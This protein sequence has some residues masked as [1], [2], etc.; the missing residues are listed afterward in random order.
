MSRM[1][2]VRDILLEYLCKGGFDG[3]CSCTD[4]DD[5]YCHCTLDDLMPCT[6]GRNMWVDC[7]TCVPEV[8]CTVEDKPDEV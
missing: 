1:P 2:T 8:Y 7:A 6:D 3:L 4:S 5:G